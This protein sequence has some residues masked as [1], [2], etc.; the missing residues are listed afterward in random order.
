[1][2]KVFIGVDPHKLS[3]TIEV[4]D[5]HESGVGDRP[6]RHRQGRV[7][8][9]AQARRGLAASGSGR[10]RAATA[11]AGRWRS[12]CSPTASTWS[13]CRP[14]FGP[15]AVARHR[16]QPQDRRPRRARGRGGRGPH[17]GAAGAV[18]RRRAGGAADAG[19]PPRGAH[20]GPGPDRQPAAPAAV[21]T[22]PGQ[23]EEGHH[24]RPGQGDPRLGAA[25]GPGREDPPAARGRAARRAGRDREEDQGPRPRS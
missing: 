23:G 3:A 4:V 16:A 2:A 9:D 18:L 17:P 19:R 5:E 7:R 24:H 8:R 13:T 14:S 25:P 11:P 10:S 6:V 22:H 15:G 12:G 20:P 1:M 21:R